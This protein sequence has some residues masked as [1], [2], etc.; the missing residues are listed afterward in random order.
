MAVSDATTTRAPVPEK[1][2]GDRIVEPDRL[3][4]REQPFPYINLDDGL[5][6][7]TS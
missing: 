6:G 1:G 5:V 2:A 3:D 7:L 4:P